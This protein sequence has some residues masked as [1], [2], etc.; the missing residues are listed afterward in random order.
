ARPPNTFA[1]QRRNELRRTCSVAVRVVPDPR[2][3]VN[4]A[5]IGVVAGGRTQRGVE[6]RIRGG[7]IAARADSGEY[8]RIEMDLV[9][10]GLEADQAVGVGRP[11]SNVEDVMIGA[12]VAAQ[13]VV[14]C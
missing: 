10:S 6:P 11:R 7:E 14:A 12:G 9:G 1:H 8:A 4:D 2:S 13:I 5:V 3:V